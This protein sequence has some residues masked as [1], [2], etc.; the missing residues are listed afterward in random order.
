MPI[1]SVKC[2]SIPHNNPTTGTGIM[3]PTRHKRCL[4][5]VPERC[6]ILNSLVSKMMVYSMEYTRPL[7]L[8][9]RPSIM[10]ARP[11]MLQA[12]PSSLQARPASLQ[13]WPSLLQARPLTL[14]ARPASLQAAPATL[15]E[16]QVIVAGLY[17]IVEG[18]TRKH[19]K[20]SEF[21]EFYKK[22]IIIIYF[23]ES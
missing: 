6:P 4:D 2:I 9:A 22:R 14:Q 7:M 1:S 20:R 18:R 10:Q 11:L 23:F 19:A 12:R 17:L 5:R 16:W 3:L 13:A 21:I 8:Q 15:P